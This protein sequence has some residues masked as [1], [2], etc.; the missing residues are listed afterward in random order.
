MNLVLRGTLMRSFCRLLFVGLAVVLPIL[1]AMRLLGPS[2][3][4]GMR[5]DGFVWAERLNTRRIDS[6]Y[7]VGLYGDSLCLGSFHERWPEDY[8]EPR[9][10]FDDD[11]IPDRT[12]WMRDGGVAFGGVPTFIG[13]SIYSN[14]RNIGG[15]ICSNSGTMLPAWFVSILAMIPAFL[16][17]F[18][19]LRDRR[20]RR[21][22]R[23]GLC[24]EC[25]YD[26]RAS[27]DCCPE[28]GTA[29]IHP[30]A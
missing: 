27:F 20:R 6:E 1:W 25:G 3:G 28:C 9:M 16:L 13:F 5:S 29:V 19:A 24:P 10:W 22:R 8:G 23:C 26:L 15:Y 21:R 4:P 30:A 14:S 2:I 17:A 18:Q 12:G 7:G 11:G